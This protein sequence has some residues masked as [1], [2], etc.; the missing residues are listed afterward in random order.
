MLMYIVG[1]QQVLDKISGHKHVSMLM[2]T[3]GVQ[4]RPSVSLISHLDSRS[5]V[6]NSSEWEA[7]ARGLLVLSQP[8]VHD[9]ILSSWALCCRLEDPLESLSQ[10]NT[11]VLT[12]GN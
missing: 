12:N 7:E 3:V 11:L 1:V 10:C 6:Y 5:P 2:C 4:L 8:G 9:E